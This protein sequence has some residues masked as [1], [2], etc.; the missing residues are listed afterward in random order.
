[1]ES[2]LKVA[3]E[4]NR[5]R[6]TS[7][8]TTPSFNMGHHLPHLTAQKTMDLSFR[9]LLSHRRE[10]KI[11]EKRDNAKS[12]KMESNEAL[13]TGGRGGGK[14]GSPERKK[15]GDRAG[16]DNSVKE[17]RGK[18]ETETGIMFKGFQPGIVS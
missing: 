8:V 15:E 7:H 2:F 11:E 5:K 16:Q 13:G 4:S 10:K 6:R 14:K 3:A 17:K 1:V 9:R 12:E 18:Q